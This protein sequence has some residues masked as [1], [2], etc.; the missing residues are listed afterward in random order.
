MNLNSIKNES[1][2]NVLYDMKEPTDDE[3]SRV[4]V[5]KDRLEIA[6]CGG[7]RYGGCGNK[8]NLFTAR[9][10][11]GYLICPRCGKRN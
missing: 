4:V 8:F 5:P 11:N 2:L 10:E 7:S 6:W 9:Y 3:L 1:L